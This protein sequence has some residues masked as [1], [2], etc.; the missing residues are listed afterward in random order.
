MFCFFLDEKLQAE[1]RPNGQ[2]AGTHSSDQLPF[3]VDRIDLVPPNEG[4]LVTGQVNDL[5]THD[6]IPQGTTEAGY[7]AYHKC[8]D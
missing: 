7:I 6:T 5:L 3:D 4:D 8:Q 1:M 2:S